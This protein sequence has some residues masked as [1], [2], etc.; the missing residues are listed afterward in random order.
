MQQSDVSSTTDS[1]GPSYSKSLA[2]KNPPGKKELDPQI[3]QYQTFISLH[4]KEAQTSTEQWTS[5]A[6]ESVKTR[7][8]KELSKFY[9]HIHTM[10]KT[11]QDQTRTIHSHADEISFLHHKVEDMKPGEFEKMMFATKMDKLKDLIKDEVT[12]EFKQENNRLQLTIE[13]MSKELKFL[14]EK[15]NHMLAEHASQIGDTQ[16]IAHSLGGVSNLGTTTVLVLPILYVAL[17]YQ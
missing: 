1:S 4:L 2:L 17:V 16:A 10:E 11:L 8:T 9:S 3:N 7:L 6:V 12:K 5:R 13:I 15:H 14:Q